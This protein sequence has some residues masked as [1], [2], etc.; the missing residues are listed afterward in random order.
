[1]NTS[2]L[3]LLYDKQKAWGLLA[4][5]DLSGCDHKMIQSPKDIKNFVLA[6]IKKI[7]MKAHGPMYLKKFGE[8]SLAG[9]SVMQFIETSSVTVHLDDKLGDR[10]FIDI[11][12]CKFFNPNE[13][14]KFAK[15]YFKAK[16]S[17]LKVLLRH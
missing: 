14:K 7:K 4:S 15:T 10:A 12:S 16:K 11:F 9:H 17:R 2:S 6:L 8:K 5:I 3:R 13:A 1:M